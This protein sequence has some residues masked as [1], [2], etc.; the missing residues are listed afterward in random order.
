MLRPFT[1]T[2]FL[3]KTRSRPYLLHFRMRIALR[4][5]G[6]VGWVEHYSKSYQKDVQKSTQPTH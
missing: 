1:E 2:R 6:I 3:K 4:G 5:K